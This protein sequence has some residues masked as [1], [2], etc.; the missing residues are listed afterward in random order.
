MHFNYISHDSL[1]TIIWNQA[2]VIAVSGFV[3]KSYIS[4]WIVCRWSAMFTKV[5]NNL[6][7]SYPAVLDSEFKAIGLISM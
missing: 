7:G 5:N 1:L 2:S 3:K 4:V 6:H